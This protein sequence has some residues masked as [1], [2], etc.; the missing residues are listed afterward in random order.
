[1]CG[2]FAYLNYCVARDR[3]FVVDTLLNGLKRL[4]YRGYDSAGVAIDGDSNVGESTAIA[5]IK[6]RGKVAALEQT[7]NAQ[8]IILLSLMLILNYLQSLDWSKK[9]ET[10]LGIAHTRWAT[11]GPPN[12]VLDF[13]QELQLSC[14]G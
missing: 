11:H 10:H 12:E 13:T 14:L 9:F 2:I 6:Q 5:L 7:I 3:K 8:V 1:M 4:E